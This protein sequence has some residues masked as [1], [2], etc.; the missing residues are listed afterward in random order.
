M[1]VDLLSGVGTKQDKKGADANWSANLYVKC[2]YC[3]EIVDILTTEEYTADWAYTFG[4]LENKENVNA[5]VECPR[6]KL[7]FVVRNTKW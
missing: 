1:E 7:I 5:E 2:P 4:V 3:G 6:C